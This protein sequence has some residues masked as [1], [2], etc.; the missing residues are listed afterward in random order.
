MSL[1][2]TL[3]PAAIALSTSLTSSAVGILTSL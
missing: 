3:L 2:L 1:T